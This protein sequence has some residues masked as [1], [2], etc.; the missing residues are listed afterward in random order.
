MIDEIRKAGMQCE[1]GYELLVKD[2]FVFCQNPQCKVGDKFK[3]VIP[4]SMIPKN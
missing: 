3:R 1:C 4:D 2:E